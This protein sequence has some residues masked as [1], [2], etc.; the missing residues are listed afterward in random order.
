MATAPTLEERVA[1]VGAASHLV[2]DLTQCTFLDSA[3]VRTLTSIARD[4]N[5]SGSTLALVAT[6]P[7]ILR[8]LEITAVD[9]FLPVHSTVDDAL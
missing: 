8:V 7:G 4:S 3:A 1:S 9:E 2:V 5:A 6:D